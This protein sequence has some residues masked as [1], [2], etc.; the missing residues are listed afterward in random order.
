MLHYAMYLSVMNHPGL[1]SFSQSQV[2]F[3]G[4]WIATPLANIQIDK[5]GV[6]VGVL[7]RGLGGLCFRGL[8]CEPKK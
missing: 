1:A 5:S 2:A 7:E 4:K 3:D 6:S 8:L